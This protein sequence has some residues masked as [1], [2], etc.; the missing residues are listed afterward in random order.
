M[1]AAA[2]WRRWGGLAWH[3]GS[4]P[5]TLTLFPSSGSR[6]E[7]YRKVHNLR[8]LACGGDGTVSPVAA[9]RAAQA[10]GRSLDHAGLTRPLLLCPSPSRSAGFSPLWTSF[11]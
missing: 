7:M 8:I 10:G 11:A 9:P 5:H 4:G 6:L 1:L 2:L 3:R